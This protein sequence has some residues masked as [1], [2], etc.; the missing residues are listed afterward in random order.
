MHAVMS[1][2]WNT[3]PFAARRPRLPPGRQVVQY[4]AS[5]VVVVRALADDEDQGPT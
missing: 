4:A 5:T 3:N 2:E 1:W